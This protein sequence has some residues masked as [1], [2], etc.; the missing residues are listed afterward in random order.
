MADGTGRPRVVDFST[1]MSGPLASYLL[2]D[3]GAEVIKIEGPR[4]GD[5]NRVIGPDIAG[6]G[7][8]HAGLNAG[9]KSLCVDAGSPEWPEIVQAAVRWAEVVIVGSRPDDARRRGLDFETV[10]ELAPEVLYCGITGYGTE[11]PLSPLP[12]H[13]LNIEALAGRIDLTFTP[14][15]IPIVPAG[16]ASSGA[17]L[18]GVF[19]ATAILGGL[20]QKSCGR[21]VSYVAVSLWGAAIW[22]NWRHLNLLLNTGTASGT[23]YSDF[24]SRYSIYTT[25]EGRAILICPIERH[26]W[27]RF[28]QATELGLENAERGRWQKGA[29]LDYGYEDEYRLISD[30]IAKRT[31]D[32]WIEAL[33][34]ADVPFAPILTPLEAARSDHANENQILRTVIHRD[35]LAH[36]VSSPIRIGSGLEESRRQADL[37]PVPELGQHDEEILTRLG[38]GHLMSSRG[39]TPPKGPTCP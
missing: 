10:I 39:R 22:W 18:A 13:G 36:V 6:T 32:E 2:R 31:V 1:H 20:Y 28:C 16:F 12:A 3:M 38:L 24:S 15:G 34:R 11:G 29:P 5:G 21:P 23:E 4:S 30:A 17:P 33:G 19:A 14:D 37:G 35:Q 27:Q 25:A 26:Y 8:F 7:K 9:A